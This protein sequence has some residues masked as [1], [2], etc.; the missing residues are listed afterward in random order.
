MSCRDCKHLGR[1]KNGEEECTEIMFHLGIEIYGWDSVEYI[2]VD[3]PDK[4]S[5]QAFEA[6]G[7]KDQT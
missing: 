7:D 1:R 2:T 4:F 6:S 5:C 3:E